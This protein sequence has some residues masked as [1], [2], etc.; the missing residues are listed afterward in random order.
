[1]CQALSSCWAYSGEQ[2]IAAGLRRVANLQEEIE[3]ERIITQ[4]DKLAMKQS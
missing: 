4:C 2:D 3:E 1:M